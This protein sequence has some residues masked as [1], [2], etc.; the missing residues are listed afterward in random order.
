MGGSRRGKKEMEE[1]GDVVVRR[2]G[3][4][5]G[6]GRRVGEGDGSGTG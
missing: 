2:V 4:G 1:E 3:E 5:V 6:R